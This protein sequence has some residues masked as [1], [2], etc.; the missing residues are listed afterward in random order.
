MTFI[1][2]PARTASDAVRQ[3]YE[4]AEASYGYLP[5]MVRLFAHRPEVMQAWTTLLGSIRGSMSPR[6]YELVTLAAAREL[7]SSY[8]MLAHAT[9][10]K[11]EGLSEGELIAIAGLEPSAP[12]DAAERSIMH[13]AAKIVR[14]ASSVTQEDIDSL[15]AHGL[16]E[17]EIF[18]I[19]AAAAVRCFYSKVLDGLGAKAD[20]TYR[21]TLGEELFS[22]LA[23]GRTPDGA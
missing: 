2:T 23:I 13:F 14:D 19:V 9:V 11:R 7:K 16:Y 20:G 6:R 1:E 3:M 4:K 12:L 15:V 10:L 22:A 8:C 18:D 21:Q 5:N 17:E